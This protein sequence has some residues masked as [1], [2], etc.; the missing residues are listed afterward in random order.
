LRSSSQHNNFFLWGPTRPDPE[1]VLAVGMEVEDLT[2]VF[3]TVEQVAT[4]PAVIWVMPSEQ[5][6]PIVLA[7]DAK[8]PLEDAWAMGRNF[9]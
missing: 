5:N 7:R 3:N 6:I 8:I 1:I 2:P 4:G 9:I